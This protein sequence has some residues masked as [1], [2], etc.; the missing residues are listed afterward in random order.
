MQLES[1]WKAYDEHAQRVKEE[2]EERKAKAKEEK[3]KRKRRREKLIKIFQAKE[4]GMYNIY[5]NNIVHTSA[6]ICLYN[7]MYTYI[8][9]ASLVPRHCSDQP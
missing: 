2:E 5:N 8:N 4:E 7:Y 6:I 1:K 3:E 9:R